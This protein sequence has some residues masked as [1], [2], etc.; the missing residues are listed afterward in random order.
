MSVVV[1]VD[2]TMQRWNLKLIFYEW[3]MTIELILIWTYENE[4]FFE[5]TMLGCYSMNLYSQNSEV[6]IDRMCRE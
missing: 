2:A 3:K 5:K 4:V 6:F 1:H